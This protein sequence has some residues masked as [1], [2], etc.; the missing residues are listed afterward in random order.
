[1]SYKTYRVMLENGRI[2]TALNPRKRE[3]ISQQPPIEIEHPSISVDKH[4]ESVQ[5]PKLQLSEP[6]V[7]NR[8]IRTIAGEPPQRYGWMA[9]I[10]V[11]T[12]EAEYG[13]DHTEGLKQKKKNWNRFKNMRYMRR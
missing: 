2:T 13:N 11:S 8:G 5:G 1:V 3:L 4:N 6:M 7:P 12:D 10:T 9:D